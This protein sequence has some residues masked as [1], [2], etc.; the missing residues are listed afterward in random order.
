M[1]LDIVGEGIEALGY[2]VGFWAFLLSAEFRASTL[3]QWRE[4]SGFEHFFT[5]IDIFASAACGLAPVAL[6]YWLIS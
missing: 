6:L 5:A 1:P 4:R 3:A 2:F